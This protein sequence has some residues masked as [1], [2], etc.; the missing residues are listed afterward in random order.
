[1]AYIWAFMD[2]FLPLCI[3]E[4][5]TFSVQS[6]YFCTNMEWEMAYKRSMVSKAGVWDWILRG[7]RYPGGD[8]SFSLL[9]GLFV[10]ICIYL[11]QLN[12]ILDTINFPP[13]CSKT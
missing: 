10:T 2:S 11:P 1:M 4:D 7:G 9:G 8:G 6:S 3:E 5:R 12:A 13:Y